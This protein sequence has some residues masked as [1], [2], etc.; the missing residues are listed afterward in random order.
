MSCNFGKIVGTTLAV[1]RKRVRHDDLRLPSELTVVQFI[2]RIVGDQGKV[3]V[4]LK[5]DYNLCCSSVPP[6]QTNKEHEDCNRLPDS[7]ATV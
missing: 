3:A 4:S 6:G 7:I 5:Y 2:R 1:T